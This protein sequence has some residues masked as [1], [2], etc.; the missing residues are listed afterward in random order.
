MAKLTLVGALELLQGREHSV[1]EDVREAR[2]KDNS[3]GPRVVLEEANGGFRA[4]QPGVDLHA[5]A[6]ELE[7]LLDLRWIN[8]V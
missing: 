5:L 8:R 3:V 7:E 1:D 4:G 6:R 2:I